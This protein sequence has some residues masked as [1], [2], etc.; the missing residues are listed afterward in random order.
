M[1]ESRNFIL[2]RIRSKPMSI[3]E[4]NFDALQGPT[5]S[6]LF[7]PYDIMNLRSIATSLKLSAKPT[8]RYEAIDRI[9]RSKGFIKFGAGTNRVIYRH[10]EDTRFLVKVAADAVGMRDNPDELRQSN[11]FKPF[12]PKC[13]DISECGTVGIF[14]RVIPITSREEFLSVADSIF[15]VITE[16]FVGEYVLADIGTEFFMNWGIRKGFGPVLLDFPYI[17]E[18]DGNKLFCNKPDP[19]SPTGKCEGVIDYDDGFNFL[20][21]TKCRAKYK[22][23]E[24]AKK[25]KNKQIVLQNKELEGNKMQIKISGGSLATKKVINNESVT[26]KEEV[27]SIPTSSNGITISRVPVPKKKDKNPII[28]N[29]KVVKPITEQIS[30]PVD[31]KSNNSSRT[32]SIDMDKLETISIDMNKVDPDIKNM[33]KKD[34]KKELK[35]SVNG[36]SAERKPSDSPVEFDEKYREEAKEEVK[37]QTPSNAVVEVENSLNNIR[38]LIDVITISDVKTTTVK[39]ILMSSIDMMDENVGTMGLLSTIA[40]ILNNIIIVST[41]EN[42]LDIFGEDEVLDSIDCLKSTIDKLYKEHMKKEVGREIEVKEDTSK[43]VDPDKIVLNLG[44]GGVTKYNDTDCIHLELYADM[45]DASPDDDHLAYTDRMIPLATLTKFDSII[46]NKE[47]YD[48]LLAATESKD[49]NVEEDVSSNATYDGISFY[50]GTVMN[51]KDIV[52]TVEDPQIIIV[53]KDDEGNFINDK[54][55]NII[56]LYSIDNHNLN[57][58]KIVSKDWLDGVVKN[59]ELEKK[60]EEEEV[61]VTNKTVVVN[62]DTEEEEVE[63]IAPEEVEVVEETKEN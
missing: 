48:K 56:T 33:V 54:D 11:R 44:Y 39:N 35:K 24:L 14:E 10:P 28:K 62:K 60:E 37:K 45:V 22:A 8:A 9:M 12:I 53:P 20:Y 57:G 26:T 29:D 17:Y 4:F 58:I 43:F 18:L 63:K 13:F 38:E 36:A 16:W 2:D 21:C 40:T 34:E 5:I 47:E 31:N 50:S 1:D 15:E 32:I 6:Q 19:E 61:P 30:A 7:T 3:E 52:S 25:I 55:N 27:R 41:E 42:N 59:F 49:E 23:K 51:I 46:V